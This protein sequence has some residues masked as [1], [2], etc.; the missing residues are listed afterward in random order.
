MAKVARTGG[1]STC[2]HRQACSREFELAS[3]RVE[4]HSEKNSESK[5]GNRKGANRV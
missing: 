4:G 2:A 1:A 3:A 5:R